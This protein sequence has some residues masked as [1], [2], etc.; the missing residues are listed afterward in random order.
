MF[1]LTPEQHDRINVWLTTTVY[2]ETI[3]RQRATIKMA[4]EFVVQC[5]DAGYP[6]E[7]ASGGGLTYSFTPTS[8]G[9]VER[10]KYGEYELDLTEY[11]LW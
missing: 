11:D 4:H 10:V 8:V 7:G 2:P 5:W 1:T 6:W 9:V 3:E